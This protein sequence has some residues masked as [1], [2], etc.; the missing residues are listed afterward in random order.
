MPTPS[1]PAPT[2]ARPGSSAPSS[3]GLAPTLT[4]PGGTATAT[5]ATRRGAAQAHLPPQPNFAALK[6]PPC[7]GSAPEAPPRVRLRP[8]RSREGRHCYC[9]L[10]PRLGSPGRVLSSFQEK[11]VQLTIKDWGKETRTGLRNGAFR[12]GRNTRSLRPEAARTAASVAVM[13]A[14]AT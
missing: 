6:R 11:R 2:P 8:P 7:R 13:A 14:R 10:L 5:T 4:G 1:P 9:G 3:P 12:R